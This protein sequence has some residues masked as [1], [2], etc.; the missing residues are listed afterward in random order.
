[1]RP[2]NANT[3]K[4]SELK[5]THEQSKPQLDKMQLQQP[6]HANAQTP[7][8]NP[9]HGIHKNNPTSDVLLKQIQTT[10]SAHSIVMPSVSQI[11]FIPQH[12]VRSSPFYSSLLKFK[13]EQFNEIRF[14]FTGDFIRVPHRGNAHNKE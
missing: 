5:N 13:V 12:I 1:M 8:L 14:K 9:I 10:Q 2:V 6:I 3:S 11:S 7:P 4:V